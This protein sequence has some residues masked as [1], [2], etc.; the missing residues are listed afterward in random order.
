MANIFK[1]GYFK[2]GF[3]YKSFSNPP[4]KVHFYG[5]QVSTSTILA[6]YGDKFEFFRFNP[7]GTSTTPLE[8]LVESP[9][10]K[11]KRTKEPKHRFLK[12]KD[13]DKLLDKYFN[14]KNMQ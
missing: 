10:P 9:P 12:N 8:S 6:Q 5:I 11:P 7:F 3:K 1:Q 4:Q 2:T 13:I 14:G